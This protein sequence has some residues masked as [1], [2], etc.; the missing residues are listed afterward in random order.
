[1]IRCILIFNLQ[2]KPRVCRYYDG[3]PVNRQKTILNTL[4]TSLLK[5]NDDCC[6]IL[7]EPEL[8]GEDDRVVYRSFATLYFVIV[9][10]SAESELAMMDL[11]ET[12]VMVLDTCFNNVCELD[13][14]FNFDRVNYILDELVM[15]GMPLET[16]AEAVLEAVREAKKLESS[17]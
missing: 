3:T 17:H 16:N 14:I 13:L 10:D 4:H 5:R 2:G 9:M 6:T 8:F 7:I 12:L 15:A 1:M 11:I